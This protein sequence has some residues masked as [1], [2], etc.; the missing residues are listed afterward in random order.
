[1]CATE[2]TPSEITKYVET[3]AQRDLQIEEL[4]K[5]NKRLQLLVNSARFGSKSERQRPME[6]DRQPCLFG[7]VELPAATPQP[8]EQEIE[9]PAHT[10]R[11][12]K[13]YTDKNGNLSHFPEHL[14]R[15]DTDLKPEGS[16]TCEQCGADKE[17]ISVSSARYVSCPIIFK[18]DSFSRLRR[19]ISSVSAAVIPVSRSSHERM[20]ISLMPWLLATSET[21]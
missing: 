1:M 8:V 21:R 2:N 15:R 20:V 14:E 12:R 6:D 4:K 19:D 7:A 16:L 11:A 18:S 13:R 9:V 5:E 17:Q 3:I 10:R